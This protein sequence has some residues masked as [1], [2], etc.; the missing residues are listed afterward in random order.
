MRE[1]PSRVLVEAIWAAGGRVKAFDPQ[2]MTACEQLYGQREDMTYCDSKE[3]AIDDADC[4][5]ICTE[6][7]AFWAPDFEDIKCR[8]AS[9]VIIDGR[10]LYNPA[11]MEELDI[12]YYGIGRGQSVSDYSD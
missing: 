1:A 9:P 5:V 10:N 2:A 7:K 4:L 8:L 11:L 3:D 6:W 12:E